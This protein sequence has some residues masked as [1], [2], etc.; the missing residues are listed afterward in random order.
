MGNNITKVFMSLGIPLRYNDGSYRSLVD[1]LEELSNHWDK[2]SNYQ[3]DLV[4]STIEE[5]KND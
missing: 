1:I 2:L 4:G 3:Q 5:N